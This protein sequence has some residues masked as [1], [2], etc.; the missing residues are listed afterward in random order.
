[1]HYWRWRHHGDPLTTL[2]RGRKPTAGT[3]QSESRTYASYRSMVMRCTYPSCNGWDRYGGRGI[4]VAER[5]R[6]KGGF[7][8]FLTD[9]GERPDGM[10]L[11]RVDP[12]GNYEPANCRWATL[13]EQNRNKRSPKARD[14]G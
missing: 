7:A 8:R 10:T 1:M 9:M 4:T 2:K 14:H 3:V 11:D 13:S 6:G 5:W 12:E